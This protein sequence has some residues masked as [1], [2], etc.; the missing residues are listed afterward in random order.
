[1]LRCEQ[2]SYTHTWL[3]VQGFNIE[4][5]RTA[6]VGIHKHRRFPWARTFKPMTWRDPDHL[7]EVNKGFNEKGKEMFCL[8]DQ[9][10]LIKQS[11]YTSVGFNG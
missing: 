2:S 5:K 4:S 10:S 9:Y 1:M 6:H 3:N 7:C 8:L 11:K